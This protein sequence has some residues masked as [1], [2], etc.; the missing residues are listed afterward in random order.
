[1]DKGPR[2]HLLEEI[3]VEGEGGRGFYA[4][5]LGMSLKLGEDRFSAWPPE[6]HPDPK[7]RRTVVRRESPSRRASRRRK[8]SPVSGDSPGVRA[9]SPQRW[10]A[11]RELRPQVRPERGALAPD[12]PGAHRWAGLAVAM[13][14]ATVALNLVLCRFSGVLKE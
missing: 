14:T 4:T 12:A 13:V 11:W 3:R 1:M 7:R 9:G 8:H 5:F 10:W 6:I 2:S